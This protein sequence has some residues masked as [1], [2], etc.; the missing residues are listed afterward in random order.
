MTP[1]MRGV[2]CVGRL[3]AS[4]ASVLL[5]TAVAAP[6]CA[7][8]LPTAVVPP[9]ASAGPA[10][11]YSGALVADWFT[12]ALQLTQQT[13]GF[14][15]P[16]AARALAYLSLALYE[17][18]L[19]GMADHRSLAGQLNELSSLPWAQPDE[20][21]H[22]PTVANAAMATMTRMMHGNASADDKARIDLL[23]RNM[24]LQHAQDF[25]PATLTPEIRNR[26]DSFGRLMAMELMTW[27]RTDDGHEVW[28]PLRR[29]IRSYV[30]RAAKASGAPRRRPS[31][32]HC[33]RAGA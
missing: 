26:S 13:P 27:A 23:E 7:Q 10:S 22:W 11:T 29:G 20:V 17:S 5:L 19:P 4:L 28:G 32:R 14:S 9:I 6:V 21:L 18:V 2:F 30:S 12:L 8:S 16:V 33:C 25:D 3:R 1:A 31:R 15:P 24:V